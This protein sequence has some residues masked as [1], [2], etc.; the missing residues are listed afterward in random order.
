M[1]IVR[2]WFMPKESHRS[3]SQLAAVY[4]PAIYVVITVV[5]YAV[6][7]ASYNPS[8]LASLNDWKAYL[9]LSVVLFFPAVTVIIYARALPAERP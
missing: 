2:K 4:V 5:L 7:T 6:L 8:Q 3:G 1:V 9:A